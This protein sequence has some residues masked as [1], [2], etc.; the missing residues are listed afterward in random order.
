MRIQSTLLLCFV[1]W[2][3]AVTVSAAKP[4]GFPDENERTPEE[5][6]EDARLKSEHYEFVSFG[7]LP[8]YGYCYFRTYCYLL[9]V[10]SKHMF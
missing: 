4:G 1:C 3:A 10:L 7:Q 2:L 5:L 9:T 8:H 6:E